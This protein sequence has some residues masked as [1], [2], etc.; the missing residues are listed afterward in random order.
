MIN[1][2]WNYSAG[3][4]YTF[5]KMRSL[6]DYWYMKEQLWKPETS[7]NYNYNYNENIL[8]LYAKGSFNAKHISVVAGLRGEYTKTKNPKQRLLIKV[9]STCSQMRT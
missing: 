6:A 7:M 5:N 9:I 2:K 4:K 3:A 8:G 1:N